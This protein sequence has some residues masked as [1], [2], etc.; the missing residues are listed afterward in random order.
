MNVFF[1]NSNPIKCASEHCLVH[2][3]K[4]IVEYAQ[5]LSSA[6]HVIDGDNSIDGIYKKTHQGHPSSV[7]VRESSTHYQWVLDCAV[8]LCRLYTERTGK[9][10]KTQLTLA[11][12]EV[13]PSGIDIIEFKTPPVVADDKF[14]AMAITTGSVCKAYQEYLIEKFEEWT[15]RI[16][17]I[18]VDFHITPE[19]IN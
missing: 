15:S 13:M 9:T 6:H 16:K 8:E 12:L 3:R 10:H 17:P 11:N 19:W 7:W 5:L 4:M 2:Q 18:A 14:K 1:T